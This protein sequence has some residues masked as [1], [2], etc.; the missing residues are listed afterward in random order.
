MTKTMKTTKLAIL[1]TALGIFVCSISSAHAGQKGNPN[2]GILPP[3]A[4]FKGKTAG[5]WSVVWWQWVL[6]T[7]GF[8]QMFDA[9]GDDA[10]VNHNG[11]DGVFFLAKTWAGIP[12]TRTVTVPAG[13]ALLI[14]VMG[15]ADFRPPGEIVSVED[16]LNAIPIS[17]MRDLEISIDGNPVAALEDGNFHYLNYFGVDG[18][19]PRVTLFD[20]TVLEFVGYEISLILAPLPPGHHL[21]EM[22]GKTGPISDTFVSDVTYHL[23]VN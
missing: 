14:P 5:E 13:T 19:F 9:T 6:G 22:K 12:Q 20:G 7:P 17:N 10:Y 3:G 2:P 21:I 23:T 4:V 8:A 11:A 18:D 1:I 15:T 16:S